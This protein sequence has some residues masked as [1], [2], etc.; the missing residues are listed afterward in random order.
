MWRE[1]PGVW[2]GVSP[3]HSNGPELPRH[4]PSPAALGGTQGRPQCL[5]EGAWAPRW[6]LV[7]NGG[8]VAQWGPGSPEWQPLDQAEELAAHLESVAVNFPLG[9]LLGGG[10]LGVMAAPTPWLM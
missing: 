1:G 4:G 8:S 2:Q 9:L 6:G 5:L 7:G 3:P 10:G